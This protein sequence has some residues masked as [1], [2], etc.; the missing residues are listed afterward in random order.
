MSTVSS[1]TQSPSVAAAASSAASSTSSS[2]GIANEST[3]LTL[4]VAQL[5]NQDPMSPADSTQFVTQ[6]AQFSSLEQL[7]N[8]NTNVGNIETVVNP[9]AAA[10]TS[11]SSGSSKSAANSNAAMQS[12]IG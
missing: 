7:Q 2:G 12:L 3:F 4:L 10:G 6:L 8:I 9:T 5:K 11:S 1:A